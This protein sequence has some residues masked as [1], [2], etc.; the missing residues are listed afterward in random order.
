MCARAGSL[1]GDG[2]RRLLHIGVLRGHLSLLPMAFIFPI[3]SPAERAGYVCFPRLSPLFSPQ[4]CVTDANQPSSE[5][6]GHPPRCLCPCLRR[7]KSS[8][9]R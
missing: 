8:L 5:A 9:P 7:G 2:K 4:F 6:A 3:S 1:R